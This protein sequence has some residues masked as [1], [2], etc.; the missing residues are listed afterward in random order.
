DTQIAGRCS[1]TRIVEPRQLDDLAFVRASRL[2]HPNPD[3]V[4]ALGDRIGAYARACRHRRLAW[5]RDA[6]SVGRED[7]PMI[8]A[9]Q[10][11]ALTLAKRQRRRAMAAAVFERGRL[12]AVAAIEHDLLTQERARDRFGGKVLRPDRGVSGVLGKLHARLL[13]WLAK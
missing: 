12:A 6:G 7:E 11:V 5:D 1:P 13:M 3:R 2:A 10:I 9:T 8:A 4:P